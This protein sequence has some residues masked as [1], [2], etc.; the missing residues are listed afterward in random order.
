MQIL[1]KTRESKLFSKILFA[2]LVST[3]IF[4]FSF[5]VLAQ[6]AAQENSQ[7]IYQSNVFADVAAMQR[8]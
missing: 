6:D 2:V 1:S 3:L 7:N 8:K 5:G 4:S